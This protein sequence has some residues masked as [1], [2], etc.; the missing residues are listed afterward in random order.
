MKRR[1]LDFVLILIFVWGCMIFGLWFIDNLIVPMS[2]PGVRRYIINI[3]QV[4]VSAAMVFLWL[5]I[6]R[7]IATSMFWRAIGNN[8]NK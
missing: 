8:Q 1:I 3:V 4:V 7:W 6:W 2:I 5:G